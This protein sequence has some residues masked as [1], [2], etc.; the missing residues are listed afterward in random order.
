MRLLFVGLFTTVYL[1]VF[2]FFSLGLLARYVH[3]NA[4]W[5]LQAIALA[6][7]AL[8]A[9]L[10]CL[11]AA[12]AVV[13]RWILVALG[14]AALLLFASRYTDGS[15]E[16]PPRNG[17]LLTVTT[18]NAGHVLDKRDRTSRGL[19]QLVRAYESDIFSLQEFPMFYDTPEGRMPR[20]AARLLAALDYDVLAP[21]PP[22]GHHR[23]PPIGT[24]LPVE[25]ASVIGLGTPFG[26][27]RSTALRAQLSWA[28]R[29]IV[30]YNIHLASFS[31][32][33]PWR[34]GRT[35]SPRAWIRFLRDA[36]RAF[37]QRAA[38]AEEIRAHADAEE[39]PLL[40]C[41]DFNTTPHQW[42]YARLADG[43]TDTYRSAGELWGP[44]FPSSFPLV[45]IDFVLADASWTAV[46]ADVG[47]DL[48]PDHRPLTVRL[49]LLDDDEDG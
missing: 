39:F 27:R 16:S 41:G 2:V 45:R 37:L 44:T 6:L 11:T 15:W 24:T 21:E 12:A 5:W 4:I 8:A 25:E 30:V 13:S 33:R 38:E 35:L 43:L 20:D 23:T 31:S 26:G 32:R 48:P 46:E 34:D 29:S 3:P 7:P 47:P 36:K 17:D 14:A 49:R 18:F 22:E 10:L 1:L 28:G 40:V 9:L 42:A 19:E